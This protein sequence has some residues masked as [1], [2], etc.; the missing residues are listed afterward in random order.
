MQFNDR[1]LKYA[2]AGVE[3]RRQ[4]IGVFLCHPLNT[5]TELGSVNGPE[6][7]SKLNWVQ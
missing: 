6:L 5:F 3:H 7:N 1:Q 2:Y 4:L